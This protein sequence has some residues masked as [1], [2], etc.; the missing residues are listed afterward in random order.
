MTP[1]PGRAGMG[2]CAFSR[3][4]SLLSSLH[5]GGLFQQLSGAAGAK[6]PGDGHNLHRIGA[7]LF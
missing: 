3:L 4:W 2:R 6:L 1:H 7:G 5:I